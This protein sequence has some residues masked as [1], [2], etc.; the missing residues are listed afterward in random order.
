MKRVV[1]IIIFGA[2][3]NGCAQ[4]FSPEALADPYGF[5]SGLWHGIIFP[6]SLIANLLS[7]L[8][9][10]TG[11]SF[12]QEVQIIGRPNTGLW[13]YIGFVLGLGA[14]MGGRLK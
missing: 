5:M 12:L 14:S 2:L 10:L 1:L 13:Y 6:F 11:F 8:L 3:L 7:W 9:S 4:H